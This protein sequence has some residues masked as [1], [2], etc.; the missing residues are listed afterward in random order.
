MKYMMTVIS[1]FSFGRIQDCIESIR[2]FIPNPNIL[3]IDNN[4]SMS[5]SRIRKKS[6][7]KGKHQGR[8]PDIRYCEA[9]RDWLKP[10]LDLKYFRT[11]RCC[12][13]GEAINVAVEWCYENHVHTMVH[14]EPDC[15][16]TG[17]GWLSN[18]LNAIDQGAW[19]AGSR[20]KPSGELHPTPSAWLVDQAINLDF[21]HVPREEVVDEKLFDISK[22]GHW[23]KLWWDTGLKAWYECAKQ[24]K[25][26]QVLAPGI[27]HLAGRSHKGDYR[28]ILHK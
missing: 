9:E 15:S 14:I 26:K 19:M 5:D 1:Y 10:Q 20:R 16:I 8:F 23:R 12:T 3:V 24:H 17:S 28:R 27:A 6:F 11:D 13:H 2:K 22:T 25:T 21:R 18:L 4:P 7:Q